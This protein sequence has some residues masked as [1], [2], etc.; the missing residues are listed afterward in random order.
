MAI[1]LDCLDH[2]NPLFQ[3]LGVLKCLDIIDLQTVLFMYKVYYSCLPSHSQRIF[4]KRDTT[5]SLRACHDLEKICVHSTLRSKNMC[6]YEMQLWNYLCN[7][8]HRN[9]DNINAF[10]SKYK[11]SLFTNM[12]PK[13]RDCNRTEICYFKMG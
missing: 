7:N 10:K 8:T 4:V 5:Y 6:V 9:I 13:K 3:H 2:T 12:L 11:K 1:I